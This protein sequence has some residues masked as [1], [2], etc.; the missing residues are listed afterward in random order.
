MKKIQDTKVKITVPGEIVQAVV[1]TQKRVNEGKETDIYAAR[2]VLA[3]W[4]NMQL[5]TEA[6]IY[7]ELMYQYKM[8][9]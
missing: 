2:L 7:N 4:L 3:E 8:Y 9:L 1:S 5:D 6:E